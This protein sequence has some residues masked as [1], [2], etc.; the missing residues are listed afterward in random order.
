MRNT[1]CVVLCAGDILHHKTLHVI[2]VLSK[3]LS[4][5]H[6]EVTS[7]KCKSSDESRADA[8][9]RALVRIWCGKIILT[10]LF[11]TSDHGP[12]MLSCYVMVTNVCVQYSARVRN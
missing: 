11:P 12:G 10:V 6:S 9:W 2:R 5:Q 8:F 3:R 4:E 7:G 1:P